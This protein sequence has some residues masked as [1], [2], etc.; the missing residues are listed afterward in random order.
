MATDNLY[1]ASNGT[2]AITGIQLSLVCEE[3]GDTVG[4]EV[5]Y[6]TMQKED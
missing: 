5:V 1:R 4:Q 2:G 6:E 3:S